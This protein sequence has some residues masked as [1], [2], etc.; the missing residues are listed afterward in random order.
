MSVIQTNSS[1]THTF[2]NVT[3]FA[4]DYIKKYFDEDFFK[5]VHVSTKLAYRQLDI[6]RKKGGQPLDCPPF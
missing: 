2:G 5:V 3:C 4:L 1:V 6:L